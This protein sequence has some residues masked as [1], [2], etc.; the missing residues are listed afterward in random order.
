[1]L[2]KELERKGR[3]ENYNICKLPLFQFVHALMYVRVEMKR[4]WGREGPDI[5][6]FLAVCPDR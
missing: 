4:Q 5:S 1:M 2:K 3:R 6:K